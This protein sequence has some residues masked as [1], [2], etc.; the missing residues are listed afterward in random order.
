MWPVRAG[1]KSLW[2]SLLTSSPTSVRS[3]LQALGAISLLASLSEK[4]L[5]SGWQS[6]V[7]E[8]EHLV[9]QSEG[10]G[11]W[12][13]FHF[14]SMDGSGR[15]SDGAVKMHDTVKESCTGSNNCPPRSGS[16]RR[17]CSK[18]TY[19]HTMA[20]WQVLLQ[21]ILGGRDVFSHCWQEQRT[22]RSSTCKSERL[23]PTLYQ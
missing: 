10:E 9:R 4:R 11:W 21:D 8:I 19:P 13:S 2:H 22:A 1:N 7:S 5:C 17:V 14:L 6:W 23:N 20:H 3:S 16:K 15:R 12:L 18:M